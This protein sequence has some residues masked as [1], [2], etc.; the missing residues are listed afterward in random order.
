VGV[1]FLFA[2]ISSS[3]YICWGVTLEDKY[4]AM[5]YLILPLAVLSWVMAVVYK[6]KRTDAGYLRF[7][8]FHFFTFAI[9]GGMSAAVGNFRLNLTF[10]GWF[11]FVKCLL[12]CL[13]FWLGLKLRTS[14]ARL[15]PQEL[16]DFLCQTVLVKGTAAMGTMLFFSFE[17]V[18]CL[19]SQ[20]SLDNGQCRNTSTAAMFLSLYLVILTTLSMASKSV[21]KSVQIET[22]SELSSIASLKGLKWWQQIQGGLM[23]ITAIAS[24]YLLGNLGVEGNEDS[25]VVIVGGAGAVSLLVAGLVNMAML[26]LT[27]NSHQQQQRNITIQSP[28]TQRL[29]RA[30]SSGK[31]EEEM[32]AIALI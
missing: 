4:W 10:Y 15:P 12:Y 26:V 30:I 31:V 24:M 25:M 28:T 6:P 14:A 21:P 20:N 2:L 23:T 8:Y 27:R 17:I 22:A 29:F 7:L 5:A 13:A 1:S 9:V 32:F 3:L 19:I 16:S 18:S 11:V